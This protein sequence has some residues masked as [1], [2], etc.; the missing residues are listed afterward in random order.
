MNINTL[1]H[2]CC[3][4]AALFLAPLLPGIINKVKAFFA[5]RQ[6]PK[7]T[8]LYK[9]LGKLIRKEC[10]ISS[11]SGGIL[12]LAPS[13]I[14]VFTVLSAMLL[15]A[16]FFM[17]PLKFEGD[18]LL[19]FYLL[20]TCR[21]AMVLAALDTGSSFEGMGASREVF[22]SA[23]A[24]AAVFAVLAFLALFSGKLSL[25]HMLCIS[26]VDS[27]M[28]FTPVMLVIFS[29]FLILLAENCRVPFDDPETHLELTMIHEAMILDYAGPD[30]AAILYSSSLKLW[31]FAGLITSLLIP[32]GV[33]PVWGE[34]LLSFGGIFLCA[35]IVGIVESSMARYRFLKV[36]PLLTAALVLPVIAILFYFFFQGGVQ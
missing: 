5:G 34:I 23:L 33:F 26:G 30:L 19:F 11:T 24:E 15:P 18:A 14:L 22:F 25:S 3:F 20:G 27:W 28:D 8:Q 4:I 32:P 13:V 36:P 10:V 12:K 31:I 2:L 17:S 7:V 6:G 29:L 16:G 1:T 21:I 9:D 35:V